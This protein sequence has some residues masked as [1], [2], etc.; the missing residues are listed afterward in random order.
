MSLSHQFGLG[1]SIPKI[2]FFPKRLCRVS[3]IWLK[4][5]ITESGRCD[6]DAVLQSRRRLGCERFQELRVEES[7]QIAIFQRVVSCLLIFLMSQLLRI[8][9]SF[10]KFL[11]DIVRSAVFFQKYLSTCGKIWVSYNYLRKNVI[12]RKSWQLLLIEKRV[13]SE[14]TLFSVESWKLTIP[15]KPGIAHNLVSATYGKEISKPQLQHLLIKNI[16][17]AK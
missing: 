12:I 4:N 13:D 9:N 3:E 5:R 16:R 17:C 14:S 7:T 6:L 15:Q 8:V 11:L 10:W 2:G 1:F